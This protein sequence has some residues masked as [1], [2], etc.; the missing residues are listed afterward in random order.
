MP[1]M[2]GIELVTQFREWELIHRHGEPLQ[3][4]YGLTG[5]KSDELASCCQKAGMQHV[6]TKP[7]L[8]D[9]ALEILNSQLI[10]QNL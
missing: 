2:S 5:Q 8:I 7:L 10:K 4:I 6:F 9:E 1:G 3:I